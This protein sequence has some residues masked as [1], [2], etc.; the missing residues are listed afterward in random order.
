MDGERRPAEQRRGVEVVD[1]DPVAPVA[2][3]GQQG[4]ADQGPRHLE[5]AAEQQDVAERRPEPDAPG[6]RRRPWPAPPPPRPRCRPPPRTSSA[7]ASAPR[8]PSPSPRTA[9]SGS[10]APAHRRRA[11]PPRAR[12]RGSARRPGARGT[13]PPGW[14]AACRPAVSSA[15][16]NVDHDLITDTTVNSAAR[17]KM[18]SIRPNS[19]ERSTP[20]P[21]RAQVESPC[22]RTSGGVADGALRPG[23]RR[24]GLGRDGGRRVRRHHRAAGGRR[25]AGPGRRRLPVDRVRAQQDPPGVGQGRPLHAHR[26]HVRPAV[27]GPGD[28]HVPDLEADPG[29]PAGDRVERRRPRALQGDGRGD[30]PGHRPD[31]R[32]QHRRTW[33]RRSATSTP[34][35]SSSAPAAGRR[36]RR[37]RG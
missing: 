10:R 14:P 29:R 15:S 7:P 25:R 16:Q 27:G 35:S 8:R 2:R 24:D 36:S 37:S 18:T 23:D 3:Q 12:A 31:H 34:A 1:D 33:S 28:R 30:H 26:R 32:P 9:R 22:R 6:R 4:V 5:H 13:P 11:P 20:N 17:P 19:V 21:K